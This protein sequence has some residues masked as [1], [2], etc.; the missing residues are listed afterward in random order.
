MA[1]FAA[2]SL[3]A[4]RALDAA[5]FA[6]AVPLFACSTMP[7]IE[8]VKADVAAEAAVLRGDAGFNGDVGR[9]T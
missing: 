3:E 9:P 7:A 4:V 1:A 8:A 5:V 2:F 6:V